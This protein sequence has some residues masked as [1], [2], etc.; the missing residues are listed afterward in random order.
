MG[1]QSSNLNE[2]TIKKLLKEN[3][4]IDVSK[5]NKID[6]G[7][8]G[9]SVSRLKMK[10][11]GGREHT[12]DIFRMATTAADGPGA[13]AGAAGGGLDGSGICPGGLGAAEHPPYLAGRIRQHL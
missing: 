2:N 11:L 3:Y 13:D 1:I 6:R 5:V 9:C 4:K 7:T 10:P 12:Y 8:D